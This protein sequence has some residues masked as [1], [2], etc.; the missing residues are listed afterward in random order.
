[1]HIE[2]ADIHAAI[3]KKIVKIENKIRL[4]RSVLFTQIRHGSRAFASG[5]F[6]CRQTTMMYNQ[7]TKTTNK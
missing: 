5:G 2:A 1:M 6:D 4:K 3:I 7:H